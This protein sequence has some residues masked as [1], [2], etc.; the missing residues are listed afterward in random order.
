MLSVSLLSALGATELKQ[1]DLIVSE[2][3][4]FE[5]VGRDARSIATVAQLSSF[6]AKSI[7]DELADSTYINPRTVL[8]QL[9]EAGTL[10]DSQA[11]QVQISQLGFVTLSIRWDERLDLYSAMESLVIGFIQAY[12]YASYG[13]AYL[14]RSPAKAWIIQALAST[15][16]VQLSPKMARA[17]YLEAERAIFDFQLFEAQL[18]QSI[19][20]YPIPAQS[21]ALY[22]WMKKQSLRAVDKQRIVR[23][24]LLGRDTADSLLELCSIESKTAFRE[25]WTQFLRIEQDKHRGQFMDLNRSKAWLE[26]LASFSEMTLDGSSQ[27]VRLRVNPLWAQRKSPELRRTLEARID[28]ISMALSRINPLYYNA[29]QS[30]A[31]TYQSILDASQEWEV[32][33]FFS[34]YLDAMDRAQSVHEQIAEA[35][36]SPESP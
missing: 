24:A 17:F 2:N 8:V 1:S 30:L 3:R 6:I 23:S 5:I 27:S 21:F 33:S 36:D 20:T 31:L 28:L 9:D 14:V 35:L 19:P 34:D 16:Y 15:A 12:G 26:S 7:L 22:R 10:I 29:A 18:G 25:R 13:D 32:L 4:Y 11:Y